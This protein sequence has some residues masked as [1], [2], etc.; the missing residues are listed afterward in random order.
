MGP[1]AQMTVRST[2]Q[3]FLANFDNSFRWKS[4][5]VAH[6]GSVGYSG[7]DDNPR[8][9]LTFICVLVLLRIW[10]NVQTLDFPEAVKS[11]VR[12]LNEYVVF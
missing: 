3:I 6:S 5:P 7:S 9:T 2:A 1:T 10:E 12:Q 11:G 4:C 8:L